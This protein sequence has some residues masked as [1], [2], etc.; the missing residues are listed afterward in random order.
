MKSFVGW[1]NSDKETHPILKA[2]AA[3][4]QFVTIHP[5]MDGNGRTA[6]AIAT[7]MLYQAGYDLKRFYSLEEYYAEDLKGYYDTLHQ[8]QGIHYYDKPN[9]DITLWM[10]YFIKGAA[11]VFER[12]K[13]KAFSADK[14]RQPPQ[15]EKDLELLQKI[16]P[17]ERRVL[18]FFGKNL[19]L[20][21]KNLCGLFGIK[22]RAARDLAMKWIEFGLIEKK[23][24][25]NR[26]AYYVLAAEYRR[27]IGS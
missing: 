10:E 5:F 27:L 19:Q 1:I 7:L 12:V 14:K 4:Y 13:E 3:H 8:C 21:T 9:P 11:I 24:S 2:G 17:R 6:R 25:G 15:S 26:D 23:G 16:G 18:T 20:R 22:E